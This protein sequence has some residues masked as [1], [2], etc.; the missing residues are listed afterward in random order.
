MN[1]LVKALQARI[2]FLEQDVARYENARIVV[3]MELDHMR[4]KLGFH[5]DHPDAIKCPCCSREPL[6]TSLTPQGSPQ[7]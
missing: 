1:E 7:T 5:N 3:G 4:R 2:A 6:R